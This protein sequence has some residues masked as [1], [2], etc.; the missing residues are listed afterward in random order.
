MGSNI[1][2]EDLKAFTL[3]LLVL[4]A[5]VLRVKIR[6]FLGLLDPDPNPAPFTIKQKY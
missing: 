1:G 2:K 3:C 5:A 6:I 4:F